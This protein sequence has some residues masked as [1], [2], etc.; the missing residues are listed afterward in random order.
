LLPTPEGYAGVVLFTPS[1]SLQ[2]TKEAGHL[3]AAQLDVSYRGDLAQWRAAL[4]RRALLPTALSQVKLDKTS[5]WTLQTPRF[6]SSITPEMLVLTD[7][8]P[9]ALTMGFMSD[10][11]QIV[12]DIQGVRWDQD[13]RKD[14]AVE[15]WRRMRPPSDAKFELRNRFDSIRQ[16]RA[17]FDGSLTRETVDTY[18]ASSVLDVPGKKAGTVSSDLEYGV[19]VHSA[20]PPSSADTAAAITRALGAAHVLEHGVG[21]DVAQA[22]T[23]A[24]A[25]QATTLP[26][27]TTLQTT[28]L[29]ATTAL[30]TI[31]Q[32]IAPG[33]VLDE[34][35]RISDRNPEVDRS[36]GEDIRGRLM[37]E[38]LREFVHTLRGDLPGAAA[39]DADKSAWIKAQ[40]QRFAWFEAYWGEYPAL[41]HNR[42]MFADFLAKN[43]MQPTTSHGPNVLNAESE[44]LSALSSKQPTEE[45]QQRARALREAYVL[46]RSAFVKNNRSEIPATVMFSPRSSPCPPAATTTTG[47]AHPRHASDP[48]SIDVYWPRE[49]RRLG[50]EGTV[51]AALRIAPTGCVT[52]MAIIGSSGSD[53]LDGTVLKYLESA[54]F[55]PAGPSG[56]PVESKA[57][58]PVVFKLDE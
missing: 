6:V 40:R 56:K 35:Q 38:D 43:H 30:A 26:G 25:P 47:N 18:F 19:T 28:T 23:R 16:R 53:L 33:A 54:E 48:Q 36:I 2:E 31:L 20:G 51:I 55:I 21:E 44:L 7:K 1:I 29:R 27:A 11:P 41:T 5:A 32:G 13:H 50:E 12:W 24:S 9:L 52:G 22:P 49:S 10:G 45:W 34:L 58:I 14:A 37:T 57:A 3:L 4:R 8:S 42:D 39:S 17:P 46:E 15:L